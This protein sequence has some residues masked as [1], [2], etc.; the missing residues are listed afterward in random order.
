MT[1]QPDSDQLRLIVRDE[2]NKL[3]IAHLRYCPLVTSKIEERVRKL[4]T[5]QAKLYGLML[6]SGLVGGLSGVGLSS[7]IP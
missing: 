5:S 6:G 1:E 4:E 2:A 7:I 3:L